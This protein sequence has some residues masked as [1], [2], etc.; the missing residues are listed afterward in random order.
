V[1]PGYIIG[2]IVVVG[3]IV[4]GALAFF[5]TLTPYVSVAEARRSG[6]SVQVRG[7]LQESQGYDA[8]GHYRFVL[9]D[10]KGDTMTVVYEQPLPANFDQ[11]KS[12]VVGGRYDPATGF[13]RADKILVKCPSKYQEQ[14]EQNQPPAETVP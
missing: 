5:S 9:V 13:F 12:F 10:D 14:S 6:G 2:G 7:Y 8:D 3:A 4:L 11:V 1:K